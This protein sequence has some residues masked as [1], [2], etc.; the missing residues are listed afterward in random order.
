MGYSLDDLEGRLQGLQ[1]EIMI[2]D[3][4][5]QK[6][7]RGAYGIYLYHLRQMDDVR[8]RPY[9][10]WMINVHEQLSKVR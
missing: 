6:R 2:V 4:V 7:L 5:D 10:D 3:D 1:K 8:A 9:L